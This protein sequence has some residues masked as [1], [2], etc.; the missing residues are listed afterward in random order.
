MNK[1]IIIQMQ[2]QFDGLPHA[3]FLFLS[4]PSDNYEI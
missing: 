4:H 1:E 3:R 2:S